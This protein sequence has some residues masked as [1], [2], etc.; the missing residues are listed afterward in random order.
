MCLNEV[1][2]LSVRGTKKGEGRCVCTC[3][4]RGE[5]ECVCVHVENLIVHVTENEKS[6]PDTLF[7][8]S[9]FS[10]THQLMARLDFVRCSVYISLS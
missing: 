9:R 2:Q 4:G 1:D 10:H 3:Y 8:D 7:V 6:E 5:E